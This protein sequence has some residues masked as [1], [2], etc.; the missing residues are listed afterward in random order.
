M[1]SN[2]VIIGVSQVDFYNQRVVDHVVD[3]QHESLK[4]FVDSGICYIGVEVE[5]V[6]GKATFKEIEVAYQKYRTSA[7]GVLKT[8]QPVL[9]TLDKV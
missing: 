7:F 8:R 5:L 3:M 1:S 9:Y 4:V 6:E 2:V